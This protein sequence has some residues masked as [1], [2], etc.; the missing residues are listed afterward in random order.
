MEEDMSDEDG[1]NDEIEVLNEEEDDSSQRQ[2]SVVTKLAVDDKDE[3]I[4]SELELEDEM[5]DDDID[6]GD[7]ETETLDDCSELVESWEEDDER[8]ERWELLEDWSQ[9]HS[10]LT[11]NLVQ[12]PEQERELSYSVLST[13]YV[14]FTEQS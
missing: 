12:G 2:S 14:R 7:E 11:G 1:S 10:V 5:K 6:C 4:D 13:E 9:E 8:L 3:W